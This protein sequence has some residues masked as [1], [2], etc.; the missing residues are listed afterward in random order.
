[1]SDQDIIDTIADVLR[2]AELR[3]IVQ[4]PSGRAGAVLAAL[5]DAGYAIVKLPEPGEPLSAEESGLDGYCTCYP[6]RR[7]KTADCGVAAHRAAADK[8]EEGQ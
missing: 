3:P 4:S 8:A 5:R 7:G 6:E 2:Q 1:M